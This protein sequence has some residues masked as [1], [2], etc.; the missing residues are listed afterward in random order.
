LRVGDAANLTDPI[1]GEGIANAVLS[2]RLVAQAI[3]RARDPAHAERRWQ[4]SYEQRILPEL[5]TA[6][7]LR[8]LLQGTRR[9]NLAMWLLQRSQRLAE[10]FHG[11]LEGVVSYHDVLPR[12]RRRDESR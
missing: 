11:S 10:R 9:K 3:D 6:L 7:R 8:R 12:L 2:G 5:T 4:R 1:T